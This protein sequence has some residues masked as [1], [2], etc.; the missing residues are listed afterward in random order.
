MTKETVIKAEH[1]S[2][3]Y[4]YALKHTML[5]GI[6][7]IARN[8]IGLNSNSKKIRKGEF[9]ALNDISF[10]VRKGETLGIIGP[11]GSGKSTL[12]KI[13]N[14]IFLPDDGRIEIKGRI[15]ALIEVGAGF[16]PLL[17]GVENVYINGAILGMS[18]REISKKLDEIIDFADIKEFID[19]PVKHYS[20]GM[21][22]RLGFGVAVYSH[23]DIL[24]IDEVLAVGDMAFQAKCFD[25]INRLKS[26]GV[27]IVLVSHDMNKIAQYSDQVLMLNEG[28]LYCKGEAMEVISSFRALMNEHYV[29]ASRV[30]LPE[31]IDH[32]GSGEAEIIN[33][34]LLDEAGQP[35]K[36]IYTGK[37]YTFRVSIIFHKEVE[38]PIVGFIITS[39]QMRLYN[40]HTFLKGK[41]LGHFKKGQ[42][43]EASLNIRNNMLKGLY[44]LTPAISCAD[45][46]SFC[47]YR[48]GMITFQ[49]VDDGNSE[50]LIN[51]DATIEVRAGDNYYKL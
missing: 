30:E 32:F 47:D 10:E 9:W 1:V 18:K 28:K 40:T 3:K 8:A 36:I 44:S 4:C 33:A 5:Y 20:S 38:N 39:S 24:L 31:L 12:L 48:N 15:G 21:Y 42:L 7:D 22:V 37:N 50:G 45:G 26:E 6:Q 49:V 16:H 23:P 17:T 51:L 19:M 13:L 41:K 2:K 11:N 35:V 34:I 29:K 14:G 46:T 27:T 25:R 43:I